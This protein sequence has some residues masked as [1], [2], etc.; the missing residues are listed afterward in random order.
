MTDAIVRLGGIA[1]P[2]L[3]IAW[4]IAWV[5]AHLLAE[6]GSEVSVIGLIKYTKRKRAAKIDDKP[7]PAPE[8]PKNFLQQV[9]LGTFS[10]KDSL[11]LSR[12]TLLS[13]GREN[14]FS[15]IEIEAALDDLES[16]GIVDQDFDG[17][18][19]LTEI[20]RKVLIKLSKD[21][22]PF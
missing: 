10:D 13:A 19:R 2:V 18:Y 22:V 16:S 11:H 5:V 21:E 1:I 8:A 3:L 17:S 20:G 15:L 9:L 7:V 4:V 6:P 12:Q 14:E